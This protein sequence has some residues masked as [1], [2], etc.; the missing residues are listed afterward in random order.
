MNEHVCVCV[1][2]PALVVV[3]HCHTACC[4]RL[5]LIPPVAFN[6]WL[7]PTS[8][9][10]AESPAKCQNP[11]LISWVLA[12]EHTV[13][14][15]Q[16]S[17]SRTTESCD[18]CRLCCLW[19][20]QEHGECNCEPADP[21]YSVQTWFVLRLGH[22]RSDLCSALSLHYTLTRSQFNTIRFFSKE[23]LQHRDSGCWGGNL[24]SEGSLPPCTSPCILTLVLVRTRAN[25]LWLWC[26][27]K[28]QALNVHVKINLMHEW[29]PVPARNLASVDAES[30]QSYC[31]L[32]P[33]FKPGY[34]QGVHQ[35]LL[36]W[37]CTVY[38]SW[39]LVSYKTTAVLPT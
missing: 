12:K 28:V 17:Q 35:I 1:L 20:D 7:S 6:K 5:L 21:P 11:H 26:G 33:C 15:Q 3:C 38:S 19:L 31:R 2:I 36:S 16:Q 27:A 39:V 37:F 23:Q 30:P 8:W 22:K 10:M 24:L 25:W 9:L 32:M 4:Q 18:N 29:C 34:L 14:Q 13:E